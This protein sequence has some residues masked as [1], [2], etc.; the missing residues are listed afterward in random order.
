V[1]VQPVSR[2]GAENPKPGTEGTTT[3]NRIRDPFATGNRSTPR[4]PSATDV[5]SYVTGKLYSLAPT[6]QAVATLHAPAEE[7]ARKLSDYAGELEPL[8]EHA[9]RLRTHTDTL[10]WLA[11]RLTMLGCEFEVH[12][13]PELAQY[14]RAL[15]ARA[16]HAADAP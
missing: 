8:E 2:G 9:C 4:E 15:S 5:A 6:Y 1:T 10:E 14:L 3:W 16:S 7:I 12:Q 13:P 11:F